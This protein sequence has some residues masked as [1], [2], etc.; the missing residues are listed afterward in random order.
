MPFIYVQKK[1]H[2][3]LHS[4]T[5]QNS[6]TLGWKEGDFSSHTMT[7]SLRIMHEI[8]P[9][10]LCMY[11]CLHASG[12]YVPAQCEKMK[13]IHTR[14]HLCTYS[15][16]SHGLGKIALMPSS[17]KKSLTASLTHTILSHPL[18]TFPPF[19]IVLPNLDTKLTSPSSEDSLLKEKLLYHYRIQRGKLCDISTA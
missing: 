5:V 16:S 3:N 8:H 15:F 19:L 11:A 10:L 12:T 7:F 4:E 1:N 17:K 2:T 6:D 18:H 13:I 9:H 14:H